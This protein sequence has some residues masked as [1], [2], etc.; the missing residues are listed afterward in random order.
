MDYEQL[1][2]RIL[3]RVDDDAYL[4]TISPMSPAQRVALQEIEQ[5]RKNPSVSAERV[6]AKIDALYA[7]GSLSRPTYFSAL[8]VLAA[9]PKVKD[10]A[11]AARHAASQE[12]AALEEGGPRLPANLASVD[13]HRGVL[14]FLNGHFDVALDYFSRAFEREHN[15][16]NLA[17]VLATLLRLGDEAEARDLLRQVRSSLAPGLV[18]ELNARIARDPDLQLLQGDDLP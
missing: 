10:Y 5:L 2:E 11:E 1:F 17:N 8:H 4:A 18:N 12:M 9:S 15:A 16:M 7:E 13:R 14:A 6:R 3:R